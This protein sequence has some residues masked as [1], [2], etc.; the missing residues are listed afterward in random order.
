[1]VGSGFQN[2][3][4]IPELKKRILYTLALLFVY[5]IGVHVPTPG[6]DT[7]AEFL[8]EA[9]LAD[10]PF[11][12]TAVLH[13]PFRHRNEASGVRMHGFLN[14]F[15]AGV[16]AAARQ[17]AAVPPQAGRNGRQLDPGVDVLVGAH[18]A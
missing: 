15:G 7:V 14:L 3:F 12:A 17:M 2:I 16:L 6:I 10:V 8:W 11:K 9:T 18:G 5:R 4:K 13:H 1:M